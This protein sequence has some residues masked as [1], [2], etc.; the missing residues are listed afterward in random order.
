[1]VYVFIGIVVAIA[2][3]VAYGVY[4]RRQ[5]YQSVDNLDQRKGLIMSEPVAEEISRVKGL[6]ISGE[7]EEKFER[8]R[9][10]WDEIVDQRL[11]EVEMY[12]F[13]IEEIAN[14]Y[15]FRRAKDKLVDADH[16]LTA[17]EDDI[18]TIRQE[19]DQL[20]NSEEKNREEIEAATEKYKD[21]RSLLSRQW[22]SLGEAASLLEEKVKKCREELEAYDEETKSGNYMRAREHLLF[23]QETLEEAHGQIENVPKL[24]AE[25]D[26]DIPEQVREMRSNVREME[27]N[28]FS[29]RHFTVHEDL[30]EV[31]GM[32]SYLK[33][34]VSALELKDVE[35]K[36]EQIKETLTQNASLLEREAEAKNEVETGVASLKERHEN[37][38]N[39]LAELE[40]ERSGVEINY[41]LPDGDKSKMESILKEVSDVEKEGQ[42]FEDL[43]ANQKHSYTDL[44]GK[45]ENLNIRMTEIEDSINESLERLQDIRGDETRAME[46][47]KELRVWMTETQFKLQKSQLPAVPE[48]LV[49]Q[50]G[51]A[52]KELEKAT[53]ML[54]TV[55]L[56][57]KAIQEALEQSHQGIEKASHTLSE[58]VDQANWAERLLQF[59]NRYRNQ[60]AELPP[61]LN[62]A[63]NQF[64]NGY[65]EITINETTRALE[66]LVPYAFSNLQTEWGKRTQRQMALDSVK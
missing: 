7:T 18:S 13:D 26:R 12:L 22:R 1:M 36:L 45:L 61:I 11:P 20:V 42:A 52:G 43:Q 66:R 57:M 39:A 28:A 63:E 59:G 2:L 58:A 55:P 21:V 47:L 41:Q 10:T 32:L 38:L 5:I 48:A 34:N 29:F 33:Q 40:E 23:L 37:L 16:Y 46:Q 49:D 51:H 15:Q 27:E 31:D 24:L 14:K 60:F 65:Y 54:E 6:T 25:I 30:D 9:G 19:V 17:I 44:R 62:D 56:D 35:D 4:N 64:R 8:W 50:L 3:V 53:A